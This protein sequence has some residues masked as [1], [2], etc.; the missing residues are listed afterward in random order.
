MQQFTEIVSKV[1][2]HNLS[3]RECRMVFVDVGME[4]L[5]LPTFLR[6]AKAYHLRC[7]NNRLPDIRLQEEEWQEMRLSVGQTNITSAER[8]RAVAAVLLKARAL[9][10]LLVAMLSRRWTI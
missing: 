2:H 4:E 6:V 9:T 1:M 3:A 10:G 8:V 5:D 7:F